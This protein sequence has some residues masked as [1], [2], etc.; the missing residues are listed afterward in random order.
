MNYVPPANHCSV[1]NPEFYAF[2]IGRLDRYVLKLPAPLQYRW[3][4]CGGDEAKRRAY[5][6]GFSCD[7]DA[8]PLPLP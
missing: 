6:V 4:S 3:N 1:S 8:R 7:R 2:L 5:L